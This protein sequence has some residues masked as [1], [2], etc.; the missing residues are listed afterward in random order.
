[1]VMGIREVVAAEVVHAFVSSKA[2]QVFGS[3]SLDFLHIP[4]S[5]V[6]VLLV[7]FSQAELKEVFGLEFFHRRWLFLSTI[8]VYMVSSLS[9]I[10]IMALGLARHPHIDKEFLEGLSKVC[11]L[12]VQVNR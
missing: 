3:S 6:L 10:E 9:T 11:S 8:T 12:F 4:L 7:G 2:L 5:E 1:M